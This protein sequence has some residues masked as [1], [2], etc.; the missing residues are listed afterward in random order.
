[1][2]DSKVRLRQLTERLTLLQIDYSEFLSNEC[3]ADDDY[4]YKKES[5]MEAIEL[6]RSDREACQTEHTKHTEQLNLCIYNCA[7]Y[8]STFIA[9]SVHFY[10][11][12]KYRFLPFCY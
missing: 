6:A 7:K 2:Y 4:L 9:T 3:K 8:K 12:N 11:H 10:V 5:L 1:M